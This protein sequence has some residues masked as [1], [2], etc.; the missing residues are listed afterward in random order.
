MVATLEAKTR[1]N[2]VF[3]TVVWIGVD[4]GLTVSI[5]VDLGAL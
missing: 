4:A 1:M 2:L 5:G 3:G